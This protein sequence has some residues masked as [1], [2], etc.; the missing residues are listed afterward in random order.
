MWASTAQ[1]ASDYIVSLAREKGVR[2]VVKGKSMATEEIALNHRLED[3]GVEA[4]ETDLGEYMIQLAGETPYHIIAPA[5]HKT[6]Q[7]FGQ[8]F[9]EHLSHTV[10]KKTPNA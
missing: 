10:P 9:S 3:V 2:T 4:I 7:D 8:L 6:R 1:E 5:I